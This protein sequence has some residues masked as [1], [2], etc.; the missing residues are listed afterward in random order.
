MRHGCGTPLDTRSTHPSPHT[1]CLPLPNIP[2]YLPE[3]APLL[4]F[5]TEC[6]SQLGPSTGQLHALSSLGPTDQLPSS[7]SSSS[8]SSATRTDP[9]LINVLNSPLLPE[10]LIRPCDYPL[11]H[12]DTVPSTPMTMSPHATNDDQISEPR[13]TSTSTSSSIPSGHTHRLGCY[14]CSDIVAATNSQRDRSLDQQCTV[15]R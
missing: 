4:S 14:F 7:S 8:S 11:A 1:S 3:I 2:L 5:D 10:S 12:Q 15:T 13:P 6:P 9:R